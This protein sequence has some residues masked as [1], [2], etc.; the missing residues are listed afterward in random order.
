MDTRYWGPSG[1][2]LFH[3]I[4]FKSKNPEELLLTIKDVLPCKFCR[5]STTQ[6][7]HE[8]PLRGN[9]GKWLYDLHNKVNH[10]LRIQSQ[11]DSNVINP[12][13]DPSFEDVKEKY[14]TMKP[15]NIPGRDFLFSIAINYPDD[16][17]EDQMATQRHFL[18]VLSKVFPFHDFESYYN[19]NPPDLKNKQTYMK[20][21]YR[22]LK[23]L[24][25]TFSVNIPT[26]KGYVQRAM[27]YKGGCSKKTYKGKTCRKLDGGGRTK[28]RDHRK[29]QKISHSVLL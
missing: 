28:H 25:K 26:Y 14:D 29:T 11:Q 2:Q 18:K 9:P 1:W 6:F 12:G 19:S 7:V 24:S 27:Y 17:T 5:E 15:K 4:A 20:W 21:M 13:P 3:L 23:H 22:L 8:L 10:K 16:P